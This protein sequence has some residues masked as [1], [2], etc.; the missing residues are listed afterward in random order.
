MQE[1]KV[2]SEIVYTNILRMFFRKIRRKNKG[3]VCSEIY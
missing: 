3:F 1:M 2:P